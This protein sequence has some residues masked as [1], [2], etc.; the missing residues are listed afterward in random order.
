LTASVPNA[1][2]AR[3]V[4]RRIIRHW[5][6]YLLLLPVILYFA[7]FHYAPMYGIQI[8]FRDYSL[9]G[10]ITGSPWVGAY[11][12]ERFFRSY[13]FKRLI[14]NTLGISLYQ[15][16]VGFPLPILLAVMLNEVRNI[17]FKKTVQMATYAPHFLSSIVLVGMIITFLSPRNGIINKFIVFFGGEVTNFMVN[18]GAFKTIYVLSGVWQSTGWNSIIYVAALAGIN[19]ELFEA[20]KI[21]G[22]GKLQ[23][24]AYITLP[25]LFPTAVILL[26]LNCGQL[27]SVGFE[28]V[29]LMQNDA[30]RSA[31][32]VISTYVYSQG[33]LGGQFSFA[34]AVGLFNAVV[35]FFL[36][37]TVNWLS[38]RNSGAG[39]F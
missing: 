1:R 3:R 9:K 4:W 33:L 38:K 17:K 15:L 19:P 13:Y 23:R 36:L 37:L 14:Q 34:A 5:Q 31:S 28:K 7:I 8:A 12:F 35:N 25:S 16:T 21:D 27:M 11:Y 39:L 18:P 30:N 6:L 2:S 32:D 22:A 10:G 20:A 24:I 26:I 29:F